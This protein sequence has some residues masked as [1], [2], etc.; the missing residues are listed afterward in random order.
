[1]G[2][3]GSCL[4][5]AAT[6]LGGL[7]LT[8]LPLL[9]DVPKVAA[10][11]APVHGIV[12]RVMQGVGSPDLIVP[13][14][15]SPHGNAL[16]P[17]Q[18]RALQAADLVV[19]IGPEL[20]PWLEKPVTSL[21]GSAAQIVLLDLPGTV[22]HAYRDRHDAEPGEANAGHEDHDDHDD[23]GE[24]H[25]DHD[26]HDHD[27]TDPHAWLDPE[28]GKLW[29]AAVAEALALADP[30]NAELYR[31]N[32]AAG[33]AELAQIQGRIAEDL[34]YVPAASYVTFHDAYQ[35]FEARFGLRP[36]GSVTLSD[37]SDPSPAQLARVRDAVAG[38]QV[39]CALSGPQFDP[40]LLMTA[41]EGQAVQVD[42][43]D[44]LGTRIDLGPQFYGALLLAMA[45]TIANCTG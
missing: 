32:A 29:M 17:S 12:A 34:A 1:M 13:S 14:N 16:R 44:P 20:T 8:T 40:A 23:H 3:T 38:G 37:A 22:T 10:D 36:A 19:W 25:D 2:F 43:L 7:A 42:V 9:A 39:T 15:A 5:G 6:A 18:A 33:Q 11:I 26:D 30:G 4:S 28:N 27:G 41:A 35:Y 31:A 21:A 24:G 45:A